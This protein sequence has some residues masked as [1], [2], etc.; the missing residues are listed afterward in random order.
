M[1][2]SELKIGNWIQNHK[3]ETIRVD[4]EFIMNSEKYYFKD[5][6]TEMIQTLPPRPV[7]EPIFLTEEWLKR[8]GFQLGKNL[9]W[10]DE[11]LNAVL[12]VSQIN[13]KNDWWD[14]V[15]ADKFAHH[16][17]WLRSVTHVHQLQN[18]FFALTEKELTMENGI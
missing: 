14:V 2:A 10:I 1:K 17:F 4:G 6:K 8:F 18:L 7:F 16:G 12:Q 9:Y 11:R 13:P 3:G 5:G 15:I